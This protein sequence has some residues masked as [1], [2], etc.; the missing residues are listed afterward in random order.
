MQGPAQPVQPPYQGLLLAQLSEER[1]PQAG[2]AGALVLHQGRQLVLVPH[3]AQG[4]RLEQGAQHGGQGR[5][6]RLVHQAHIKVPARQQG[7]ADAQRCDPH[8][9]PH[10]L[11]SSAS[12]LL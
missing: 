10:A 8:L 4:P 9:Q 6:P 7:V 3:Q 12:S 2:L 11:L 1:V 5:L